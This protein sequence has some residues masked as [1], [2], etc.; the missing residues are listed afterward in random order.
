MIAFFKNYRIQNSIINLCLT[1]NYDI[2]SVGKPKL[3]CSFCFI[4]NTKWVEKF[5]STGF[6]GMGSRST[7]K[8]EEIDPK[9]PSFYRCILC[10]H[11][12]NM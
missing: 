3:Q 5:E 2:M 7:G 6:L 11:S 1:F 10:C 9:A 4:T 8:V 12:C